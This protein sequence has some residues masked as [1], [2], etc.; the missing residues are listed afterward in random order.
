MKR[1]FNKNLAVITGC[2]SG[3]GK[4]L[5]E[6]FLQ[7]GYSV[8]I[9][10]LQD[11]P[12]PP[13]RQLYTEQ[14]DITDEN[15]IIKFH[16]TL[17]GV[18][19]KGL[20][21]TYLINNAGIAM[22]GPV[23]NLPVKIFRQVFEVNF[24]GLIS[25]TQKEIPRLIKDRGRIIIV[26]SMA[27]KIAMPFLSPYSASKFALEGLSDSLRRELLPFGVKVVLLEPGGIATPIWSKAKKQD[28]SFIGERYLHSMKIFEEKFIDPNLK[29]MPPN[30]AAV[31]IFRIIGKKHL[32]SR[33]LIAEN[34]VAAYLP[35][36]IPVKLFD[37][38]VLKLFD[39]NY[40][41]KDY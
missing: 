35:L 19:K 5:A 41:K 22:G 39:M 15:S 24:F 36:L 13:G 25:L 28:T 40:G 8:L 30:K 18:L 29:A 38:L 26:G 27:G 17:L 23:E 4:S 37:S 1:N 31:K 9:S 34:K 2:D 11:N 32:K 6:V 20:K 14:L 33:Y 3:I 10:Y 7:N 21:L 12:F 16:K